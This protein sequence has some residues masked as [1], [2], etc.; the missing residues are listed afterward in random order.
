MSQ[1]NV[2][3]GYVYFHPD[4]PFGEGDRERLVSPRSFQLVLKPKA[5]AVPCVLRLK[6]LNQRVR[7]R[8]VTLSLRRQVFFRQ[9]S[10]SLL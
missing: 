7:A 10:G 9:S 2:L 4:E 6:I 5:E 1:V 3:M 8:A